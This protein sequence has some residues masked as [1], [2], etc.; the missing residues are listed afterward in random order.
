M[1][2]TRINTP[3]NSGVCTSS[4]D[5]ISVVSFQSKYL[6]SENILNSTD[7]QSSK[8]AAIR[9]ACTHG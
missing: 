1:C 6:F 2:V 5:L 4:V 9:T 7:S 8:G 3:N